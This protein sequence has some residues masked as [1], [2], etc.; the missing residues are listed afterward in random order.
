MNGDVPEEEVK[1]RAQQALWAESDFKRQKD[2]MRNDHLVQ[3]YESSN[4]GDPLG[5]RANASSWKINWKHENG[6]PR[7][8]ES[9]NNYFS[10]E[11]KRSIDSWT[12][13]L[14]P[15]DNDDDIT[16]QKEL[17][18][19]Y[20][21][22]EE[23]LRPFRLEKE[24]ARRRAVQEYP[25]DVVAAENRRNERQAQACISNAMNG[26]ATAMVHIAAVGEAA[27]LESVPGTKAVAAKEA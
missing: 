26:K 2:L 12:P 18:R 16:R 27:T 4:P 1:Y 10:R 7:R 19:Q 9:W 13:S 22:S 8:G 3:R 23:Q 21:Y 6:E 5:L 25:P 14:P 24:T 11:R 20:E 17:D 15:A